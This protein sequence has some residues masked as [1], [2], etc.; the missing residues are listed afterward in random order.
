MQCYGQGPWL[1]SFLCNHKLWSQ[2]EIL[3]DW[4]NCCFVHKLKFLTSCALSYSI[5][6]K[7]K[8]VSVWRLEFEDILVMLQFIMCTWV[9]AIGWKRYWAKIDQLQNS[10]AMFPNCADVDTQDETVHY[11]WY[12]GKECRGRI[13][14]KS[15]LM[16]DI[17]WW[18]HGIC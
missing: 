6:I 11:C 17:S 15:S 18:K 1:I 13:E 3:S 4:V 12:W 14:G 10:L 9:S 16:D 8:F 7:N 2:W 5:H